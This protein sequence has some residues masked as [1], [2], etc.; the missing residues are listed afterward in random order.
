MIRAMITKAK[1][2]ELGINSWDISKISGSKIFVLY[3]G[4]TYGKLYQSATW[5]VCGVGFKTDPDGPWYNHGMKTFNVWKRDEKQ[6]QLAE[7]IKWASETYG[8][9]NWEKDP[10]GDYQVAGA[11]QEAIRIKK[12]K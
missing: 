8:I 9:A 2:R 3:T 7:A 6:S 5:Q 11:I 10:F 12:G 4:P 1:L